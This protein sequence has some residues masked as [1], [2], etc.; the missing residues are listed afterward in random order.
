VTSDQATQLI[1][2]VSQLLSYQAIIT[3]ILMG[4]IFVAIVQAWGSR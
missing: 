4:L 2:L 3:E 1:T